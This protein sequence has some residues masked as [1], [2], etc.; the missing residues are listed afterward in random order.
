MRSEQRLFA[1]ATPFPHHI[2]QVN[3]YGA[4]WS[5]GYRNIQMLCS[6]LIQLRDYRRVLFHGQFNHMEDG[7]QAA[8]AVKQMEIVELQQWIETAWKAGFDTAGALEFGYSL[9]GK[10]D[11]IGTTECAALLRYFGVRALIVDFHCRETP[12][13]RELQMQ[14]QSLAKGNYDA[15]SDE[16][17]DIDGNGN[18]NGNGNGGDE[19]EETSTS[20]ASNGEERRSIQGME[21]QDLDVANC[22][23]SVHTTTLE[24]DTPFVHAQERSDRMLAVSIMTKEV[25]AQHQRRSGRISSFGY[26]P[27][28]AVML[29]Q[30]KKKNKKKMMQKSTQRKEMSTAELHD[31]GSRLAQWAKKYFSYQWTTGVDDFEVPNLHPPLYFQYMGHS[32]SIVGIEYRWPEHLP[33]RWVPPPDKPSSMKPLESYFGVSA[34]G[35][36]TP[37]SS[38]STAIAIDVVVKNSDSSFSS[39]VTTNGANTP[40]SAAWITDASVEFL[41]I[42]DPISRSSVL[43]QHL[44]GPSSKSKATADVKINKN[45]Q[46]MIKKMPRT[47]RRY[48]AHQICFVAPGIMTPGSAEY[49]RSKILRGIMDT[50]PIET[51]L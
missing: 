35:V 46:R 4:A 25:E 6:S 14:R 39:N 7:N 8:L 26:R 50:A 12:P 3:K 9:Q 32:R 31:M 16:D 34:S 45:W 5:C 27:L 24:S 21:D 17:D 36:D 29:H 47:M 19:P 20:L 37:S 22:S 10:D 40:T 15:E 23:P 2:T 49:E 18:D 33:Q 1:I 43:Q 13:K 51:S 42:F 11:W 48:C 30:T 38:S 44:L 41:L 28:H